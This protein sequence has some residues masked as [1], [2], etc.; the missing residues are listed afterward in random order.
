MERKPRPSPMMPE[1]PPPTP[2]VTPTPTPASQPVYEAEQHAAALDGLLVRYEGGLM[3]I[4]VL[5]L[6]F[7]ILRLLGV[8]LRR[9]W[10]ALMGHS[11]QTGEKKS[12]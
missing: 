12:K 4:Y 1:P 7:L 3:T 5:V 6:A 9:G 10:N 11:Q 8:Y 2:Q